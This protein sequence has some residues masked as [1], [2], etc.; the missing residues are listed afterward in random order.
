MNYAISVNKIETEGYYFNVYDLD[1]EYHKNKGKFIK[2]RVFLNNGY[3]YF[4]KN[5]FGDLCGDTISLKCAIE[6]SEYM[7]DK[8]INEFLKDTENQN[9]PIVS[10]WNWGKYDIKKDSI[11][12]QSF[13][14]HFGDY[15][16]TEEKG[17][18]I[19]SN[20]FRILNIKDYRT[21]QE[22]SVDEL[23]M[24]KYYDVN[25][26]YNKIPKLLLFDGDG[27]LR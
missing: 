14:N 19:D 2:M 4:V 21:N 15:Y 27:K 26:L 16:L 3:T 13:Y 24:F 10:L 6:K 9:R 5:G 8:N 1:K 22:T 17:V 23:Y 7:L 25:K 20:S 18:V 11:L 12:I